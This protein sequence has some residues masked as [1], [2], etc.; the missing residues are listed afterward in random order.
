MF[1]TD[2]VMAEDLF[3]IDDLIDGVS[4]N[5]KVIE[6]LL[7]YLPQDR[8][9]RICN[10][11]TKTY[12]IEQLRNAT[13]HAHFVNVYSTQQFNFKMIKSNGTWIVDRIVPNAY[14]HDGVVSSRIVY[15]FNKQQDRVGGGRIETIGDI[16]DTK[17]KSRP[18][19]EALK[20]ESLSALLFGNELS[21]EEIRA[22]MLNRDDDE[23]SKIVIL[24]GDRFYIYKNGC[25]T[26]CLSGPIKRLKKKFR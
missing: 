25:L 6:R 18:T 10:K 20:H 1:E 13:P 26:T 23:H 4:I 9:E 24:H 17:D 16:P 19:R 2:Q 15:E 12:L 3:S 5:E 11:L 14:I 8:A 21:Q 22:F 7:R